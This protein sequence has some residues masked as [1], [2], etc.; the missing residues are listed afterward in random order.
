MLAIAKKTKKKKTDHS[1]KF[2]HGST[3][4]CLYLNHTWSKS[5]KD[6]QFGKHYGFSNPL[7]FRSHLSIT[8]MTQLQGRTNSLRKNKPISI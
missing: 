2:L 7:T 6:E 1:A 8:C 5:K 3:G 4:G